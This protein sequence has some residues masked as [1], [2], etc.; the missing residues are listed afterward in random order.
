MGKDCKYCGAYISDIV[1][2]CPACGKKVK[3]EKASNVETYESARGAATAKAKPE[4]PKEEK[5]SDAEQNTAYT[6]KQEYERR[7]GE[8][9]E[10]EKTRQRR[11]ETH[12][13]GVSAE[14][15]DVRQNKAICYLCYLGPLFLIPYLTRRDSSFVRYHS[16][17]GLLLLLAN[18]ICNL[19]G[20][21]PIVGWLIELLGVFFV[22]GGLFNGLSNVSKGI[23]K[24][25]PI[26]GEIK[27]L[28]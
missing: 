13:V 27:I 23:K 12:S 11:T 3:G 28:D 24:P 1:E 25:L 4:A 16:N 26:I 5:R 18:V 21:V 7:Y 19:C 9:R 17:Q 8:Y 20:V 14:D 15:E 10:A 22:L 6:Y 2:L